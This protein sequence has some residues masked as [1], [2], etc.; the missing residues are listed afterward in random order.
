MAE[1]R[2]SHEST[3]PEFLA[4]LASPTDPHGGVAAAAVAAAMGASLLQMV[5]ALSTDDR[6]QAALAKTGAALVHIQH[7]LLETVETETAVKLFAA[8]RLPHAITSERV[9]RE[10]AIQV[11]LR[12]STEVPLEVMRLCVRA[13]QHADTV[14]RHSRRTTSADVA[15]AVALV[16]AAFN[17]ARSAVEAKL[18]VLT[19]ASHAAS[20]AAQVAGLSENAAAG[21]AAARSFITVPPT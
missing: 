12:A 1:L 14:A 6:D 15:L 10:N 8:C 18:P 21:A 16:E 2:F 13:L 7:D 3:I 19:D 9:E 17:A 11:A 5:S 4:A 20:L